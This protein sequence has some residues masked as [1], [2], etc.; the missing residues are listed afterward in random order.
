MSNRNFTNSVSDLSSQHCIVLVLFVSAPV[1][2]ARG[3]LLNFKNLLP[4]DE[5]WKKPTILV[6]CYLVLPQIKHIQHYMSLLNRVF[7]FI[8]SLCSCQNCFVTTMVTIK[9]VL[10]FWSVQ[11]HLN[12]LLLYLR[13]IPLDQE[14]LVYCC[15]PTSFARRVV[16]HHQGGEVV[17]NS[18]S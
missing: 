1:R 3:L 12:S 17:I 11:D 13:Y 7:A 14:E 5:L 2:I 10:S 16:R 18:V 9:L 15:C 8:H 4:V 6:R